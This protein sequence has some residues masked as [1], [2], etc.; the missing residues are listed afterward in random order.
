[1]NDRTATRSE[2]A[3]A[4]TVILYGIAAAVVVGVATTLRVL[5]TFRDGGIAWTIEI[6]EQQIRATAGSGAVAVNGIAREAMVVATGVN[7]VSTAAIIGAIVL[8][9]VAALLVIG[10]VMFVA[11]SFL[12]GRFFLR[13]NARAF[14]V[15]GWTL[16]AAPL[17]IVMLE[18]M[19]LNGILVAIGLGDAD[20]VHPLDLWPIVPVFAIGVASGLIAA[21]FRRGIRLQRDTE[22]LV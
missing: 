11:W 20:P 5:D 3:D 6:V 13:G 10:G 4:L 2:S 8:W 17:L 12:R 1:M 19:G 16:V 9:A 14:D 15:I 18:Q 21:A 7:A 22:G